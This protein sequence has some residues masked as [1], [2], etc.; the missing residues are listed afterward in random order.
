MTMRG[1]AKRAAA[2]PGSRQLFSVYR[3]PNRGPLGVAT[4]A[5]QPRPLQL[6]IVAQVYD[7]TGSPCLTILRTDE[8]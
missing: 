8:D 7:C 5:E 6:S 3:I 4:R 1:A 2:D